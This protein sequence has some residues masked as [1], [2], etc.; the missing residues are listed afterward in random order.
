MKISD[1]I[2]LDGK[3]VEIPGCSRNDLP[4]FFI[5]KGYKTGVEVGVFTGEYT[6]VLAGSGLEIYGVDPWLIYRDY[7]NPTAQRKMDE[8]YDEAAD[9]LE[10]YQNVT[11]IK[12]TS[13]DALRRFEDESIDFVYIDGNHHFRYVA[14]DICEWYRK[15]KSG[16][17]ICGHDYAYFK[18][19][20]PWGG[21]QAREVVD[22][23]V[24][25][26]GLKLYILG[27][28]REKTRDKYR[29]W[30]FFKP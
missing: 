30:M 25:A 24:K 2:K 6:E 11:L 22:A 1:G 26:F 7:G 3:W 12:E 13:M 9:R 29:S 8:R 15:V 18:S 20:S 5:E 23:Y 10:K 28:Y 17:A 16:G 14:D 19:R 27:K 4:E 21:C